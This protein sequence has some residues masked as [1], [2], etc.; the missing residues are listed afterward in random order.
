MD[1]APRL[2]TK[3]TPEE[4]AETAEN[5][6]DHGRYSQAARCYDR[7]G[8]PRERDVAEAYYLRE[9]AS[10][11]PPDRRFTDSPRT[12]AFVEAAQ[13]FLR[14]AKES[15]IQNEILAYNRIAAECFKEIRHYHEAARAYRAAE[16][17][18]RSAKLYRKAG[19]FDDAVE[20]VQ[21]YRRNIVPADAKSIID[22]AK[23][24]YL[25]HDELE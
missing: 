24:H 21:T 12:V 8:M 22:V 11:F 3:S 16:E 6:F 10:A 14:C 19:S 23:I 15:T 13:A 5:L 4:W 1:D 18:T 25:K 2:A 7:A 9:H 17:Y 20:V